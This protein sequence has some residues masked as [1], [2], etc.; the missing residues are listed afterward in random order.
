MAVNETIVTGRKFRRLIDES[1]KRWQI[2]Y[3]WTCSADVEFY[4]GKTAEQKIG[5][6]N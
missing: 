6:I 4:D 2:I 1:A 3:W 5:N